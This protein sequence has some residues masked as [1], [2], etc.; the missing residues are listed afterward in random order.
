M[1]PNFTAFLETVDK[2][3]IESKGAKANLHVFCM[4]ISDSDALVTALR[5][6]R[7]ELK[8]LE[9]GENS[10]FLSIDMKIKKEKKRFYMKQI[11]LNGWILISEGKADVGKQFLS[12]L[13]KKNEWLFSRIYLRSNQMRS[14][15]VSFC[16]KLNLENHHVSNFFA[17]RDS[18]VWGRK[19][20][21][22]ATLGIWQKNA[23]TR[24]RDYEKLQAYLTSLT[25]KASNET[26]HFECRVKRRGRFSLVRG[27]FTH[28]I[29]FLVLP[30]LDAGLE[31]LEF[32]RNRQRQIV[33]NEVVL[34]PVEY[35]LEFSLTKSHFSLLEKSIK[36]V[37]VYALIHDGNPYFLATC[38]DKRDQSIYRVAA[39]DD[40]V[41]ITPLDNATDTAL[42]RLFVSLESSFVESNPTEYI[43][44]VEQSWIPIQ[45][46]NQ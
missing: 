13:F 36:G 34:K 26:E 44:G 30:A 46:S 33:D 12:A 32:F 43:P 6:L 23:E 25:F 31:N 11:E 1:T 24:F 41:V 3:I 18:E 14:L 17:R 28:F 15:Y 38:Y 37:A 20:L 4:A 39:A 7:V 19:S 42:Q 45:Q 5:S 8:F 29:Q 10:L 27:N 22:R 21:P 9:D 35:K 16:K 2:R 40:R